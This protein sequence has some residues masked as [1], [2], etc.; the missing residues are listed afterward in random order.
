MENKNK[1]EYKGSYVIIK[2]TINS[3]TRWRRG[4]RGTEMVSCV[5]LG[6]LWLD[7]SVLGCSLWLL[8]P[9]VPGIWNRERRAEKRTEKGSVGL[10]GVDVL[11]PGN[12]GVDDG[13]RMVKGVWR[14]S[15]GAVGGCLS[16]RLGIFGILLR[17][18][19]SRVGNLNEV[20]RVWM[21]MALLVFRERVT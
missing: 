6:V 14:S 7:G 13:Y 15:G 4:G 21:A 20:E 1:A 5:S 12:P 10:T 19:P 16:L 11:G 9:V 2:V 3:Y 8:G 17:R 18:R